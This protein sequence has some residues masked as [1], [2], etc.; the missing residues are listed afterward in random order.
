MNLMWFILYNNEFYSIFF[1]HIFY[2][3]LKSFQK[4]QKDLSSRID[5]F[6]EHQDYF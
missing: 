2:N 6:V 1:S 3:Y 5:R 4:K